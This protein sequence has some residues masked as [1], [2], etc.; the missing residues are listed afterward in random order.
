M[1]CLFRSVVRCKVL[2]EF[3]T[4]DRAVTRMFQIALAMTDYSDMKF[5]DQSFGVFA[6]VFY[7][8]IMCLLFFFL[9]V[10]PVCTDREQ[11]I[12]PWRMSLVLSLESPRSDLDSSSCL[13]SLQRASRASRGPPEPPEGQKSP[14]RADRAPRGPT[15]PPEGRQGLQRTGPPEGRQGPQ[16]ADRVPRGPTEPPEGRQNLGQWRHWSR[17]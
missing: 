10:S 3:T 5:I 9:L 17:L 11:S 14:Q 4:F 6:P 1:S 15:G 7:F 13:Q 8:T 2:D 12:L 16:R